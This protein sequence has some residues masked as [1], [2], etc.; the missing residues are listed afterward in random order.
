[1]VRAA[2]GLISAISVTFSWAALPVWMLTQ[3]L[4]DGAAVNQER[5]TFVCPRPGRQGLAL[6]G[7]SRSAPQQH[8]Q[9]DRE[10]AEPAAIVFSG[11]ALAIGSKRSGR[12]PFRIK[13]IIVC[14]LI[15]CASQ[16]VGQVNTGRS[17]CPWHM[18]LDGARVSRHQITPPKAS[19]LVGLSIL[20]R[21]RFGSISEATLT[22][23]YISPSI[24]GVCHG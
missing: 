3:S 2:Q 14:V 23:F 6:S 13:S 1:V 15:S 16:K 5:S 11:N 24:L 7:A 19:A 9:I 10:V 8:L 12:Q 20:R 4:F 17:N 18:A 22:Q 21:A